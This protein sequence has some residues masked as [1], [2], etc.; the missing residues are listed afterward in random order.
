M[1]INECT[2]PVEWIVFD[3]VTILIERKVKGWTAEPESIGDLDNCFFLPVA[4]GDDDSG[5]GLHCTRMDN[6][7][8]CLYLA[9]YKCNLQYWR[10]FNVKVQA[11]RKRGFGR[12]KASSFMINGFLEKWLINIEIIIEW[13]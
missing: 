9:K 13:D 3:R 6:P 7:F 8:F 11:T 4:G 2:C 5:G 10:G 1:E 12:W